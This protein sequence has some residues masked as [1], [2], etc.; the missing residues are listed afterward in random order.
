M[1]DQTKLT[2]WAWRAV[3]GI[4]VLALVSNLALIFLTMGKG[5]KRSSRRKRPPSRNPSSWPRCW[6]RPP[7]P[8]DHE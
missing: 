8:G 1:F 5:A 6:H 2:R 4:A 3:V 7:G